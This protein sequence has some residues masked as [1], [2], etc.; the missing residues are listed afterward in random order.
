[1]EKRKGRKKM[2]RR[3]WERNWLAAGERGLCVFRGLGFKMNGRL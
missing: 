3:C 2:R 1:M